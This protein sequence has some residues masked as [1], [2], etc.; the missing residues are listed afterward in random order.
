MQGMF[1]REMIGKIGKRSGNCVISVIWRKSLFARQICTRECT[2][3][4]CARDLIARSWLAL[5]TGCSTVNRCI[6]GQILQ[7]EQMKQM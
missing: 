1:V 7:G 6:N 5:D 4:A 2:T 3:A